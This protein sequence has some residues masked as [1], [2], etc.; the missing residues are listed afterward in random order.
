MLDVNEKRTHDL[1]HV[2][3]IVT[4]KKLL[5]GIDIV[6]SLVFKIYAFEFRRFA[7]R[8]VTRTEVLR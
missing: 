7:T 5:A 4:I 2:S 6:E 1:S 8:Y 3:Q